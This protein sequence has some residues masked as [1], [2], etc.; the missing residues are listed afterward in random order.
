MIN[1]Q[2]QWA[3]LCM[4]FVVQ[5]FVWAQEPSG[6]E[7]Q[8]EETSG[9]EATVL[10]VDADI[11]LRQLVVTLRPMR[12]QQLE[13]VLEAWLMKLEA[14]VSHTAEYTFRIDSGDLSAEDR[15]QF[16][17]LEKISHTEEFEIAKRA[18]LVISALKSK[19]GD[20]SEAQA[21]IDAATDIS[22]DLNSSG[23]VE[24]IYALIF[25]WFK[26]PDGG[27]VFVGRVIGAILLIALFW[28]FGRL[29]RWGVKR[30][31]LKQFKV[32]RILR[33]FV[34]RSVGW[35]VFLIGL[36]FALSSLG[37]SVG[38]IMT[39][40]GAGGFI[41]GFALQETLG[42][43]ASGMMIMVY[44]PFDEGDFVEISGVS[45]KVEKMSL[46]STTLLTFDNKELIIPNKKAWGQTIINYTGREIRRVDLIFSISY[47]DNA[48]L[49]CK[50]LRK[51]ADEHTLVLQNPVTKVG[52]HA[53]ADSSVNLFLRPW[54]RTDDYWDV[55]Y[56]LIQ[57]A[58]IRLESAGMTIPFPQTDMHIYPQTV[59][60]N[61]DTIEAD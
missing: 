3:T 11:A 14:Q 20:V 34:I 52:V 30:A 40:L 19:G 29:L 7:S 38:P 54:C 33:D 57:M 59:G 27:A 23:R 9:A 53:L 60:A 28:G 31:F 1:L 39:A 13:T 24:Y 47:S 35:V 4:L 45:G 41:I 51:M 21:Y 2:K 5:S 58:K 26:D 42:N 36:M 55:H 50:V 18:K 15:E 6:K 32:S 48:K 44:Q 25:N 22:S 17:A 56:E 8:A 46:V 49:A 16:I 61:V 10:Y 12:K 43:F 37:V